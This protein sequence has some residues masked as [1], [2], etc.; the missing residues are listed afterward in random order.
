MSNGAF[1][2]LERFQITMIEGLMDDGEEANFGVHE[3]PPWALLAFVVC[4]AFGALLGFRAR[5]HDA[6]AQGQFGRDD[7]NVACPSCGGSWPGGIG[8]GVA[9][10]Q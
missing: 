1:P 2:Y 7:A 10:R 8:R 3:T 9:R 6:P 4:L 5:P